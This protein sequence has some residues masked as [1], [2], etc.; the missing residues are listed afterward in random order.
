[1]RLYGKKTLLNSARFLRSKLVSHGLILGY[2]RIADIDWDPFSLSVTPENFSQHLQVL[3]ECANVL[4][5]H[6][7]HT[8]MEE[9]SIPP[10]SVAITFDDGYVDN[11]YAAKPL[12]ESFRFAAT[13]FISTGYLGGEFWWDTLSR[14]VRSADGSGGL[15]LRIGQ[16]FHEW[17]PDS[18]WEW[19]DRTSLL[20]TIYQL[21]LPLDVAARAKCL[22]HLDNWP[23]V[24]NSQGIQNTAMSESEVIHLAAD[25]SMYVGAHTVSHPMLATLAPE[26]QRDEIMRSKVM[27]ETLLGQQVTGFSFPNGSK[28]A[29][30][31][32]IVRECGFTYA[33]ASQKDIVWRRSD[34]FDLPRFWV[35]NCQADQFRRW[36]NY[37]L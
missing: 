33:C 19:C 13:V 20:H 1:M 4:P 29:E 36:L 14:M 9:G 30:S 21:L 17:R 23:G 37:W 22:A 34:P 5:L 24:K 16:S 26:N 6:D 12:L 18:D 2:H 32:R 28:C 10:R 11:L 31:F 7:L 8:A 35:P 3:S 27:L 25:D 15:S